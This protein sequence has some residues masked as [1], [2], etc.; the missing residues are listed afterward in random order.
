M[1]TQARDNI[2]SGACFVLDA[3]AADRGGGGGGGGDNKSF[4]K[5][6]SLEQQQ[7]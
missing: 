7:N 1:D 3:R 2:L 5:L 4:L 6:K